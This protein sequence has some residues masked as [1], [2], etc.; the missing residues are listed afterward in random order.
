MVSTNAR[1]GQTFWLVRSR[2]HGQI[3]IVL[4]P[5]SSAKKIYHPISRKYALLS[6]K[7]EW[8]TNITLMGDGCWAVHALQSHKWHEFIVFMFV[9]PC[10]LAVCHIKEE[11]S[12][13]S[14]DFHV[15]REKLQPSFLSFLSLCLLFFLPLLPDSSKT[16]T[17]LKTWQLFWFAETV[18]IVLLFFTQFFS[19]CFYFT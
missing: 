17:G 2:W 18:C 14:H 4:W 7:I 1:G 10:N 6:V 15:D 3:V 16:S 19:C 5:N 11:I 8:T 9:T 12:P 13:Q